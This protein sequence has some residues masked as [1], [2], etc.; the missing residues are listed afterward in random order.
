VD[1][2][3]YYMQNVNQAE[4]IMVSFEERHFLQL[5]GKGNIFIVAWSD[6]FDLFNLDALDLSL[7]RCF[8]L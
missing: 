3:N 6:L 1:L 7:I 8:A 2:H 5:E 4:E